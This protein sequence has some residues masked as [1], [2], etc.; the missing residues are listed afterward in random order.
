MALAIGPDPRRFSTAPA[1]SAVPLTKINRR[2]AYDRRGVPMR[3]LKRFASVLSAGR[4]ISRIVPTLGR[5]IL[6]GLE[7]RVGRLG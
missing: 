7:M 2:L 6:V 1:A 3:W 4:K 5:T